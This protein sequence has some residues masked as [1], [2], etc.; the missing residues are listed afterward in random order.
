MP[1]WKRNEGNHELVKC[2]CRSK[3]REELIQSNE[4]ERRFRTTCKTDDAGQTLDV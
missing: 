2:R 1:C 4:V 3:R